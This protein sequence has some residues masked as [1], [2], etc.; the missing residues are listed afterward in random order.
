VIRTALLLAALLLA[1]APARA[2][3][4]DERIPDS[5]G[6]V[7]IDEPVYRG[8]RANAPIP[9]DLHI[10]N[11]GGSDGA[12]LCVISSI[13]ANGRY[14][15]VPGLEGGKD[16]T[17]WKTAKARPGG[18]Y[19][20][21]LEALL[22]EVMPGEKW[23]SWEGKGT[24]LVAEYNAKG[25]PVAATTNTG[26]LYQYQ[27]IHHMISTAHLDDDWAC[28]VDNNHPKKYHWMPRAE[29]DRRFVDGDQ[30]WG[31]VWLRKH[32]VFSAVLALAATLLGAAAALVVYG[33]QARQ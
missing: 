30:G 19:P 2:Q 26:R 31:F 10:K 15:R 21:K 14:Q 22:K 5:H 18:Y 1:A 11:E 20:G 13:L 32:R 12:G 3:A 16:S 17:L 4:P 33:A 8:V 6:E 28:I 24:D 23:F 27:P 29:Y 7:A 9:P 25:Y